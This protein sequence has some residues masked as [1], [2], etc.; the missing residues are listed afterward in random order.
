MTSAPFRYDRARIALS[1]RYNYGG[2]QKGYAHFGIFRDREPV[3][4]FQ[5]KHIDQEMHI[6]EFGII[7]QNDRVK[8]QGIGTEAIRIGMQ[9]AFNEYGIRKIYGDTMKRNLRMC[10]VFE[11]LGFRLCSYIP[12]GYDLPGGGTEDCLVW[13]KELT[14]NL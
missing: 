13:E 7:L 9:I 12:C 4:S 8:D 10:R 2:Y 14:E 5:L 3:G 6:C 1:Y 11:K